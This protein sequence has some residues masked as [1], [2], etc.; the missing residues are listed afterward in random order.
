[1]NRVGKD[2]DGS[3][4]MLNIGAIDYWFLIAEA[5]A[6]WSPNHLYPLEPAG[7]VEIKKSFHT[8]ADIRKQLQ[9]HTS[10]PKPLDPSPILNPVDPVQ[11][12]AT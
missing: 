1:M 6:L 10:I 5:G 2:M 4:L 3:F 12:N 11:P 7:F 8:S 9:E